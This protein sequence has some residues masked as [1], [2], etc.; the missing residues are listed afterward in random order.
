M[1]VKIW[2]GDDD[3]KRRKFLSLIDI[4]KFGSKEYFKNCTSIYIYNTKIYDIRVDNSNSRTYFEKHNNV[5][6]D[7]I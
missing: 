6:I 3:I 1:D 5:E 2:I 4:D 7:I